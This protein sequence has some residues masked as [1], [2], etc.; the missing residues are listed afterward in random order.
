MASDLAAPVKTGGKILTLAM[1]GAVAGRKM[2]N[3]D[4]GGDAYYELISA[5]HKS[6]RGSSPDA[7]VF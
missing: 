1:V 5:F 3:Y 4:K 6:V 2:I 7:A